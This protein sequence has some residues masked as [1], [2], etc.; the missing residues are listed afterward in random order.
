MIDGTIYPLESEIGKLYKR[1]EEDAKKNKENIPI[2]DV[3]IKCDGLELIGTHANWDSLYHEFPPDSNNLELTGGGAAV[4]H[5]KL[6]GGIKKLFVTTDELFRHIERHFGKATNE[7]YSCKWVPQLN[8][9]IKIGEIK[10]HE[11]AV[12]KMLYNGKYKKAIENERIE[13]ILNSIKFEI[14]HSI[15]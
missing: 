14:D 6:K 10:I 11:R 3:V 15:I 9:G 1:I 13:P 12:E 7:E 8:Y 2:G 5:L 4:A